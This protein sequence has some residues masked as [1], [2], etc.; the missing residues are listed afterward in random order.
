[1]PGGKADEGLLVVPYVR[2]SLHFRRSPKA[3]LNA[4]QSLDCNDYKNAT[5]QAFITP[6]HF[7]Q[8]LIAAF[9]ELYQEGLDGSPKM[10]SVGL[11]CRIVGRPA[12][13]AGLRKFIE[14]AQAKEGVW[15]A[16]RDEIAQHWR[17]RFPY[18]PPSTAAA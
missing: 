16:R 1:M 6:D 12:R 14:Y 7:A 10:M 3:S 8:Y 4:L 13:M 11:H 5:Y 2:S 9:D 18:Q 17:D 15:F